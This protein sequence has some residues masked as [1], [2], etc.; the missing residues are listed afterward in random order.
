MFLLASL[1]FLTSGQATADLSQTITNN[2]TV[3]GLNVQYCPDSM[4][5]TVEVGDLK[6]DDATDVDFL[7]LS[8]V[9]FSDQMIR[10][11]EV[12][13]CLFE[14]VI[15]QGESTSLTARRFM[16]IKKSS[17]GYFHVAIEG[18]TAK[19]KHY[20]I[21]TRMDTDPVFIGSYAAEFFD[22][23]GP[24]REL[25]GDSVLELTE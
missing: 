2:G 24:A 22:A 7:T 17:D 1:L 18:Y 15:R 23:S 11:S 19:G 13:G 21:R 4:N 9:K 3:A 16:E 10:Q 25:L 8:R 6:V 20:S 14:N 12:G 5:L